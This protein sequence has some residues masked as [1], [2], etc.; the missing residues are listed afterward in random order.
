MEQRNQFQ[1]QRGAASLLVSG[2]QERRPSRRHH[3]R[4]LPPRVRNYHEFGGSSFEKAQAQKIAKEQGV[5]P[6]QTACAWILQAPGVTA[7]IIGAT[8]THHLKQAFE[9]VDVKLSAEEVQ[10]LE[11]PYRPHPVLGHEQPRPSKMLK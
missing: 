9:S 7:P 4:R 6:T 5:T 2:D 1:Q 3:R 10:A 8:K 11:K